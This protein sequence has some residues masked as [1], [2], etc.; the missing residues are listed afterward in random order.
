MGENTFATPGR[1]AHL[2]YQF[3]NSG[4]RNCGIT[5]FGNETKWRPESGGHSSQILLNLANL[6]MDHLNEI[7]SLG[8][9]LNSQI[10]GTSQYA[11]FGEK[12]SV[13]RRRFEAKVFFVSM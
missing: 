9:Y 2:K 11:K 1:E 10:F 8:I 4:A 12:T 5:D 6:D 7:Y 13:I 3:T